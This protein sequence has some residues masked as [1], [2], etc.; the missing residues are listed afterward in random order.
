MEQISL[1]NK[2]V[3]DLQGLKGRLLSSSYCPKEGQVFQNLMKE[4]ERLFARHQQDNLIEFEYET[5]IYWC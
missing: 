2:Q 5:R 4:M 3:F 1:A